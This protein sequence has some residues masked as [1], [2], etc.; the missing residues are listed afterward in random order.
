MRLAWATSTSPE[1]TAA[2]RPDAAA[3]FSPSVARFYRGMLV[4]VLAAALGPAGFAQAS[5]M[6]M[7]R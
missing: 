5:P 2:C 7:P 1:M 6:C 3:A 4:E